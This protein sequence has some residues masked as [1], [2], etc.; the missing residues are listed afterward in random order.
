MLVI[1]KCILL[2]EKRNHDLSPA[3]QKI[4]KPFVYTKG[5]RK[6]KHEKT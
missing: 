6:N 4:K 1:L 5:N 2:M 3:M